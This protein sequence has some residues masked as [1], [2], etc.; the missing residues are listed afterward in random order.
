MDNLT[1][2]INFT[3]IIIL[4]ENYIKPAKTWYPY[5]SYWVTEFFYFQLLVFQSTLHKSKAKILVQTSRSTTR[6]L[7]QEYYMYTT[8]LYAIDIYSD[9]VS[10]IKQANYWWNNLFLIFTHYLSYLIIHRDT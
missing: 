1:N 2:A 6:F 3:R 10:Y 5:L 7:Y 8:I 4:F 9:G